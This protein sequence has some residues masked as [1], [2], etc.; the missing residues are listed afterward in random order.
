M[1]D[2]PDALLPLLPPSFLPPASDSLGEGD[3][4][5]LRALALRVGLQQTSGFAKRAIQFGTRVSNVAFKGNRSQRQRRQG[6]ED[7]FTLEH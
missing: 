5:V 1:E 6:G 4:A 3:K 2:Y 7:V